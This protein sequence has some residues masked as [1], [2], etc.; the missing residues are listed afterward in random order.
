MTVLARLDGAD[1]STTPLQK[2]MQWAV[3]KGVSDGSNPNS[4]ITR[5]Q[6]V[7]MLYRYAGSPATK[8]A[9]DFPDA[10]KV[11]TYALDAMRWAVESGIINGMTDGTLDP[12]GLAT[13]AQVAA[14]MA[15]YCQKMA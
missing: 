12:H 5:Q 14:I 7:T 6:L 15:R 8:Q 1:T 4:A 10:D 3:E 11:S 9:L 13:R 2:G